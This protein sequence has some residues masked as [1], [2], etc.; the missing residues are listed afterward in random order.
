MADDHGLPDD[1]RAAGNPA[2]QKDADARVAQLLEHAIGATDREIRV[3]NTLPPETVIR[4][5]GRR[6]TIG[7]DVWEAARRHE[8]RTGWSLRKA[9]KGQRGT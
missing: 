8:K 4:V 2:T 1:P 5:Q 6:I 7:P 3:D 9:A